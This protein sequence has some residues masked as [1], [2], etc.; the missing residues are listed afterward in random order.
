M[1]EW[2][3]KSA[4]WDQLMGD[5]GNF[6]HRALNV[7]ALESLLRPQK[8]ERMLDLACG[9]GLVTRWL[10]RLGV[11]TIGVDVSEGMLARARERG[12]QDYRRLD[13]TA[14]GHDLGR[15][16]AV[17]CSMA[18]MDIAEL[19]PL[20][21]AC[22][23]LLA[24]G[25]RLVATMTHPCFNFHGTRLFLEHEDR[26]GT[27]VETVGVKAVDYLAS[28]AVRGVGA[29]GEPNPHTYYHRSL[30]DLLGLCF[31]AGFVLDGLDERAFDSPLEGRADL[32]WTRIQ[33]IPPLLGLRFSVR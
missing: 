24:P 1:G 25:G 5:E 10:Q 32:N 2:D 20:L 26:E 12:A 15:F 6:F 21:K 8:G 17:V 11:E 9:T 14:P 3:D 22:V 19:G 29:P 13:V 33:G 23:G 27:L 18:F 28:R 7:P 4:F 16:D 31:E 30:T